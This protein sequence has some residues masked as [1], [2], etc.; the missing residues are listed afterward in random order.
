MS[1]SD[2][3]LRLTGYLVLT[4]VSHSWLLSILGA[5]VRHLR[6]PLALTSHQHSILS[7]QGAR[8][9]LNLRAEHAQNRADRSTIEFNVPK[10]FYS[11]LNIDDTPA[12]HPRMSIES[13]SS[14]SSASHLDAEDIT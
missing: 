2:P 8:L 7:L 9:I 6:T 12:H 13:S 4:I 1:I 11:A 3:T 5:M 10:H 14:S